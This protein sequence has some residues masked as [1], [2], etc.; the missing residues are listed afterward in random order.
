MAE[1][2]LTAFFLACTAAMPFHGALSVM[3]LVRI[4]AKTSWDLEAMATDSA[5]Y[6]IESA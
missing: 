3:I 4:F 5:Y 1:Q 6:E 2:I